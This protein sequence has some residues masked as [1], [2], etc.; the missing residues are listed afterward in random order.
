LN[1]DSDR[2]VHFPGFP[3]MLFVTLYLPRWTTTW[4]IPTGIRKRLTAASRRRAR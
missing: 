3:L 1:F 4:F 2:A